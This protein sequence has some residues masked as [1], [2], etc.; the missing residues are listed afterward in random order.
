MST[1][2]APIPQTLMQS[3]VLPIDRPVRILHV[4][5]ELSSGGMERAMLRLIRRSLQHDRQIPGGSAVQHGLCVLDSIKPDLA[6]ECPSDMPIWEFGNQRRL[7][8]YESWSKLRSLIK[9]FEPDVV[10]ARTTGTWFDAA[11]ALLG[12]NKV[13]LLLSFHGRTSLEAPSWRRRQIDRWATGRASAVL[14]VSHDAAR[15]LHEQLGVPRDKLVIIPN[16][17]DASRFCPPEFEGEILETRHRLRVHP[18]AD[19]AV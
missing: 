16:G 11:A 4:V 13:R 14:S 8:R 19:V 7:G 6:D 5:S 17:V 12:N 18:R 10:H 3:T 9:R 2:T 1:L 15:T